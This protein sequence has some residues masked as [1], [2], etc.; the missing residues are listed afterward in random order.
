MIMIELDRRRA[1][2]YLVLGG[3]GFLSTPLWSTDQIPVNLPQN[4][5]HPVTFGFSFSASEAEYLKKNP[6]QLFHDLGELFATKDDV[7]KNWTRTS[8][9]QSL[10]DVYNLRNLT[11]QYQMAQDFGLEI[12]QT[13]G[14]EQPFNPN[15]FPPNPN[16]K[17]GTPEYDDACKAANEKDLDLLDR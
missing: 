6:N 3:L 10:D 17:R 8:L 11:S 14:A 4:I 15:Y 7:N 16:L 2:Q 13:I 1:L 9:R 12:Y 5:D